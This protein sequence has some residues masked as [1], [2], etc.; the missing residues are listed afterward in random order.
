M[1]SSEVVGDSITATLPLMNMGK[2]D[3]L[4]AM[5]TFLHLGHVLPSARRTPGPTLVRVF[6]A[7]GATYK[8]H[9]LALAAA[10]YFI[11]TFWLKETKTPIFL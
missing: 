4:N 11:S 5:V 1:A 6:S 8:G 2:A 7:A 10:S 9:P 3:I